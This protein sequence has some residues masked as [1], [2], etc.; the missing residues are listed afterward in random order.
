M[1]GAS[2][3]IGISP[4]N[5]PEPKFRTE[6][7]W[8]KP[9]VEYPKDATVIE[10]PY[11]WDR[12]PAKQGKKEKQKPKPIT[13]RKQK[14][15]PIKKEE[16]KKEKP[17][18][19]YSVLTGKERRNWTEDEIE[20]LICMYNDGASYIDIMEAVRHSES[21]IATKLTQLRSRGR[22]A[23]VRSK[24]AWTQEEVDT[25]LTMK[26]QGHSLEKISKALGKS[27]ASVWSKNRKIEDKKE[28]KKR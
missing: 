20:K 13:I 26:D 15:T 24:D 22:I 10:I 14:Q 25:L 19:T 28:C 27:Y 18:R 3:K 5:L 11:K 17:K 21:S 16:P 2:I 4:R 23:G 9:V 6:P 1:S 12:K 7:A 8:R